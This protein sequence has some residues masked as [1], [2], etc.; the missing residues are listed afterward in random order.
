MKWI[1]AA[2]LA[3]FPTSTRAERRPILHDSI[4]L[5]IGVNCQW[6][7][8]CMSLQRSAMKRALAFMRSNR[9]PQWQLELC[10]RNAGRGGYRIDWVGFDHCIRN[11]ALKPP[12]RAVKPRVR[13]KH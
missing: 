11:A 8:R 10:N 4:A 3:I 1:L 2:A 13:S 6:Q 12:V 9:P 5:N 7:S